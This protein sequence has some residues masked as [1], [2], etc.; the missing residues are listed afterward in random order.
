MEAALVFLYKNSFVSWWILHHCEKNF[1]TDVWDSSLRNPTKDYSP[2][3]QF[4]SFSH[5]GVKLFNL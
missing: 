1:E 5:Y 4:P 2:K 3:R